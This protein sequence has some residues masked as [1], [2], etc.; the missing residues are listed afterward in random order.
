[1]L[2][3]EPLA[4]EVAAAVRLLE[5]SVVE[6]GDVRDDPDAIEAVRAAE[7]PITSFLDEQAARDVQMV[8]TQP[9][10]P[11]GGYTVF[12]RD[13][14]YVAMYGHP[15]TARLGVLGEQNAKKS[16]ARLERMITRHEKAS[17]ENIVG[18]FEIIATVA[19]AGAGPKKTYSADTSIDDL[20]PL[21]DAARENDVL[22]V[23]D[24]QPGRESF[25]DQAKR[26]EELLREP[27]VG[28][29]LDPEWRLTA[30]QKHLEQIGSVSIEEVNEVG[31]WL[32]GLTREH[33]LPQKLYVLHQ[34]RSSMIR[35]RDRLDTSHPELATLIHVDGQGPRGAK[36]DTWD[37]LRKGAPQGV[38]WGWKNFIDEDPDMLDP[39]ETW[40]KVRPTPRL[41]TYQ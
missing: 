7:D 36:F 23:I 5:G 39:K 20:R 33:A 4:P 25:L 1:M 10:L 15:N 2:T 37:H 6:I 14:R 8:R 29:A 21:V 17:G 38:T 26:Y 34:F 40:T 41:V 19:T 28:L 13:Q 11:G 18:A 3:A 12:G 22:V 30:K 27:H 9:E 16:V 24:L 31:D 32:A 35:D